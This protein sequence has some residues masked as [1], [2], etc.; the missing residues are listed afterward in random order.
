MKDETRLDNQIPEEKV[1]SERAVWAGSFL[2]GPLVAGYMI[3][4]N[5]KAVGE[6]EKVWKTWI[7][8]IVVTAIVFATIFIPLFDKVPGF[9]YFLSY[10]VIA[11]IFFRRFQSEKIDAHLAGGGELFGWGRI[12]GISILGVIAT[13]TLL[14]GAVY[15]AADFSETTT[16]KTYGTLKHEILF[17][18]SN[19]TVSEVDKIA[20]AL[21]KGGFFEQEKQKFVDAKKIGNSYEVVIYCNDSIKSDPEAVEYF[22]GLR[23]E[24]QQQ[25]PGQKIIFNLVIGT[26]DNVVKHLE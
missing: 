15:L 23:N 18:K 9:F 16:T 22:A 2:G 3:G 7:I 1:Y 25:F 24:I 17:E 21:T 19:I 8:A 6:R 4:E 26:P 13:G 11:S 12:I 5:F 20:D 14:L 10:A